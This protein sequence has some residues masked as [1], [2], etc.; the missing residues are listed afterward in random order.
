MT[1][2]THI[3]IALTFGILAGAGKPQLA[4]M[5]AGAIMPDLDHPQSFVGRVFFPVSIPLN[6]WLGHRGAFHSFW[7]WGLI[8]LCG[9]L[10]TPAYLIGA[11]GLLHILADCAT[12][13]GVR[14]F[15]PWSEKL[16]VMFRRSWRIKSGSSHEIVVLVIFGMI[17]WAGGYMGAVGGIQALIGHI[18]GAPK[19]MFEEYQTKGLQKC[20]V[21][22]KFRWASGVIEEGKWLIIGTEGQS[23]LA[24]Q[25]DDKIIHIPKD[26]EFLKARLK[27]DPEKTSWEVVQLKGWAATEEKVYFL[28][29]KQWR[30]ADPGEMVWG[31]ILGERIKLVG[32]I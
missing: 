2:P 4:V 17:A 16:F 3:A 9:L 1:G 10:W 21:K 5:A 14:G 28:D 29:G 32:D 27:P 20:H 31:Q 25:G 18:T 26:G 11:G 19:I 22:G 24:M 7:L 13:S 15:A 23:G 30:I 12:V 8:C 6:Q